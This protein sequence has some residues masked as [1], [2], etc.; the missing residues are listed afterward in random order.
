MNNPPNFAD[1]KEHGSA[2]QIIVMILKQS[3]MPL[4]IAF[5]AAVITIVPLRMRLA[6][7]VTRINWRKDK[8]KHEAEEGEMIETEFDL[9]I[10]MVIP[11]TAFLVGESMG[12]AGVLALVPLC[13]W[14]RLYAK[15]NLTKERAYLM[16]IFVTQLTHICKSV[17]YTLMGFSL[18]LHF[19]HTQTS[20]L[21]A[22]VAIFVL[23]VVTWGIYFVMTRIFKRKSVINWYRCASESGLVAYMLALLTF[24]FKVMHLVLLVSCVSF[25]ITDKVIFLIL[26]CCKLNE[27]GMVADDNEVPTKHVFIVKL[28]KVHEYL[29]DLLVLKMNDPDEG[30]SV[31]GAHQEVLV[32][33][34]SPKQDHIRMP[35][36][37]STD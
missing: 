31:G 25:L 15:P 5:L 1:E 7:Y 6:S 24:Q 12:T 3:F 36:G 32:M 35:T 34:N 26:R 13:F 30:R 33:P 9:V 20:Y 27:Y 17:A 16:R 14:L 19:K 23:P 28:N 2:G 22:C 37:E 10:L 8:Q 4:L 18:P 21:L 11:A 29:T